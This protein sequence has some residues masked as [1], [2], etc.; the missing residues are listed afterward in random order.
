MHFL[1]LNE[2]TYCSVEYRFVVLRE[3]EEGVM[4]TYHEAV[5]FEKL[6]GKKG[7][8]FVSP[9]DAFE[10]C[11][12]RLE[13]KNGWQHDRI[14]ALGLDKPNVV[15]WLRGENNTCDCEQIRP[16][17]HM[18]IKTTIGNGGVCRMHD[19]LFQE[20]SSR[21]S[22]NNYSKAIVVQEMLIAKHLR[23]ALDAGIVKTSLYDLRG[24]SFYDTWKRLISLPASVVRKLLQTE[25]EWQLPIYRTRLNVVPANVEKLPI[26]PCSLFVVLTMSGE[27]VQWFCNV[28]IPRIGIEE[29]VD[30]VVNPDGQIDT[31]GMVEYNTHCMRPEDLQMFRPGIRE[32][33]DSLPSLTCVCGHDEPS[34]PP[35]T[36]RKIQACLEVDPYPHVT[37]KVGELLN[38]TSPHEILPYVLTA[39][40]ECLSIGVSNLEMFM[41]ISQKLTTVLERIPGTDSPPAKRQRTN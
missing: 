19:D 14:Q 30:G 10:K 40:N 20:N 5:S 12:R 8:L 27:L 34:V 28:H 32:N 25:W 24:A 17:A 18:E 11:L 15:E 3:G 39:G 41:K 7:P 23:A 29:I 26:P 22:F 21:F 13:E 33:N 37:K 9:T 16:R 2:Q 6:I 36:I 4:V 31:I 1:V 35:L 38:S